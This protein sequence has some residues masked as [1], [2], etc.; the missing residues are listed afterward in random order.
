MK[1]SI[2]TTPEEFAAHLQSIRPDQIRAA[3]Q[4]FME[5]A[6]AS[7]RE[8]VQDLERRSCSSSSPRG[9]RAP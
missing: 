6:L 1:I 5:G 3:I 9:S 7:P 4:G 2:E 8:K